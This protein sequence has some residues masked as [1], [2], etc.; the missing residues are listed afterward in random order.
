MAFGSLTLVIDSVSV[1]I[2]WVVDG[3]GSE[4]TGAMIIDFLSFKFYLIFALQYCGLQLG[5]PISAW[6]LE[7]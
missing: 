6:F 3:V 2:A 1:M 4:G 7:C 5:G